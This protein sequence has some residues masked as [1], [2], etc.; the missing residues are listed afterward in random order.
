MHDM[1]TCPDCHGEKK[2]IALLCGQGKSTIREVDCSTCHGIGEITK[3]HA[4]CVTLGKMTQQWRVNNGISLREFAKFCGIAASE[5]SKI[6]HGDEEAWAEH[7]S[8]SYRKV[9]DWRNTYGK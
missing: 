6:E 7:E 1:M 9:R 4:R 3:A 8:V 2:G 5:L